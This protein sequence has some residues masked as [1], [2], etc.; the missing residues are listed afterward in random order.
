[1]DKIKKNGSGFSAEHYVGGYKPITWVRLKLV[2][3]LAKTNFQEIFNFL[4]DEN[5]LEVATDIISLLDR[6][7]KD[8]E[9]IIKGRE[10]FE[11]SWQ[12]NLFK[13]AISKIYQ[14]DDSDISEYCLGKIEIVKHILYEGTSYATPIGENF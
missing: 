7:N 8:F 4:E 11:I 2:Q 1:M 9:N 14:L 10:L 13:E 6:I 5:P 3:K 12:Y